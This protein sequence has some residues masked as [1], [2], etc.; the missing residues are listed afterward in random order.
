MKS[1]KKNLE[2]FQRPITGADL[3][4]WRISNGLNKNDAA[5]AFGLQK[6]RWA[7]LTS[8][9]QMH[10][11]IQ[12]LTIVRTYLI[13]NL[14]PETSPGKKRFE[15]RDFYK[16]YLKLSDTPGDKELFAKLIGRSVAS[17]YRLFD[18]GNVGRP[19]LQLLEAV[20]NLSTTGEKARN[21]MLSVAE[22]AEQLQK[23]QDCSKNKDT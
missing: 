14:F 11:P 20:K 23:E 12:D 21:I 3:E 2:I 5:N 17:I 7:A 13:Y 16:N 9:A 19:V 4:S 8:S 15:T 22:K 6:L 18:D 1:T 10:K